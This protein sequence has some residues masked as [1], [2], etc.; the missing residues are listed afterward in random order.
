MGLFDKMKEPV[1]LK[2]SSDA[3]AQ[4]KKLKDLVPLLNADGQEMS[5]KNIKILESGIAGEKNITSELKKSHM[6]L[7]ILHDINLD[8]SDSGSQIDYLVFTKKICF[9]IESKN[10]FGDIEITKSGDFIRTTE[11]DGMKKNERIYSPII[12]NKRHLELMKKTK[13][14]ANKGK[15]SQLMLQH[16]FEMLN[17][18]IVVLGN[19]KTVLNAKLA[20]KEIK[21]KVIRADQLTKYI[22]SFYAKSEQAQ[23]SDFQFLELA[24]SYLLLHKQITRDITAKYREYL[25]PIA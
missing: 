24:R 18:S 10:L 13:M 2:E 15:Y 19:P 20:Q 12:Q 16:F 7:Y 5:E 22:K 3:E 9:V 6:P 8:G 17:K 25:L 14:D 23:H 4:L 21:D 1:F 11:V